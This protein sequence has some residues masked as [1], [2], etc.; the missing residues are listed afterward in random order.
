MSFP[1]ML[2][3]DCH[4]K[5]FEGTDSSQLERNIARWQQ[6]DPTAIIVNMQLTSSQLSSY[7]ARAW[8]AITYRY[9]SG[10]ET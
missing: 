8:V 3:S 1:E 10:T 7:S 4:F 9:A 6:S 2:A 5:I